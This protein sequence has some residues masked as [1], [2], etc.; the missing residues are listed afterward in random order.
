MDVAP[1]ADGASWHRYMFV[2]ASSYPRTTITGLGV[3]RPLQ[4][5]T[6]HDVRVQVNS[7]YENVPP[8]LAWK[9][10]AN[11]T[12]T[13]PSEVP[14]TTT[15]HRVFAL[16]SPRRR[17]GAPASLYAVGHYFIQSRLRN[18]ASVS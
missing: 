18:S 3:G 11:T 5:G 8:G 9:R 14:K 16:R 13:A 7:G 6:S 10:M 4:P 2:T 12:G 17:G 1:V 15:P